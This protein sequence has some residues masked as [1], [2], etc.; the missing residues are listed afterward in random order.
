MFE[1]NLIFFLQNFAE[2]VVLEADRVYPEVLPELPTL[3]AMVAQEISRVPG[4][5]HS[6]D[7]GLDE[8]L[9]QFSCWGNS[10]LEA[11]QVADALRLALGRKMYWQAAFI[12]NRFARP[13]VETG[14]SREIVIV[15]FQVAQ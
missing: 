7:S 5:S 15:R 8:V 12:E 3:P 9:M 10:P 6:G 11:K 4:Y 14:L 1:E 2:L 13:D